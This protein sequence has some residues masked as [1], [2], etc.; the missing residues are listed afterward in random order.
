M[1]AGGA[2]ADAGICRKRSHASALLG[3]QHAWL[4]VVSASTTQPRAC[5]AGRA[6]AVRGDRW[7]YIRYG[8]GGE[9]LYDM[10]NDPGQF[11]NLAKV[12]EYVEAL[13]ICRAAMDEKLGMI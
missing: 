12:K 7:A 3:A 1:E 10:D 5:G 11:T 4:A 13:K 2:G 8:Q 9:E 6:R